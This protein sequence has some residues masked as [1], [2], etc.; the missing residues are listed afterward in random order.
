MR[1]LVPPVEVTDYRYVLAI[2]RPYGKIGAPLPIDLD[3]VAAEFFVQPEVL[4]RPEK[5]NIEFG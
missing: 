3:G 2:G 1:F 5:V 4:T